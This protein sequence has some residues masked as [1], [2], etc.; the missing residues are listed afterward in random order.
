MVR[1]KI[2]ESIGT[3]IT[4]FFLC[5]WINPIEIN[6]INLIFNKFKDYDT[7]SLSLVLISDSDIEN[8]EEL[9]ISRQTLSR[10][11]NN[12]DA[13]YFIF[14]VLFSGEKKD[15][16]LDLFSI[17]NQSGI[18]MS[19]VLGSNGYVIYPDPS[20]PYSAVGFSNIS[21][22]NPLYRRVFSTI[23][24]GGALLTLESISSNNI[25]EEASPY[26]G[27]FTDERYKKIILL[28][29]ESPSNIN[30]YDLD[31]LLSGNKIER[32]TNNKVVIIGYDATGLAT[33]IKNP[34]ILNDSIYPATIL[35]A[36]EIL[37][38]RNN[39]YLLVGNT[40]TIVL[41]SLGTLLIKNIFKYSFL[42][43]L[44]SISITVI[45]SF[46]FN[47]LLSSTGLILFYIIKRLSDFSFK[48]I[49]IKKLYMSDPLTGI[50]NKRGLELYIKK[51]SYFSKDIIYY[52]ML[53]IDW[54]KAINDTYGHPR[55]DE[56]IIEVAKTL[57]NTIKKK[58]AA[59]RVGGEEFCIVINIDPKVKEKDHIKIL[60]SIY[61]RISSKIA[62]KKIVHPTSTISNFITL[63]AGC[64]KTIENADKALYIS[65][66][67]SRNT[68]TYQD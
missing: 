37:S 11:I 68:F 9:P 61:E 17:E 32:D 62:D 39:Y 56:I 28:W 44:L 36:I 67:R 49:K 3:F 14:D 48:Y 22:E 57:K 40:S 27:A 33:H 1:S 53:D 58:D 18:I 63:S 8:L 38:R 64:S 23:S 19:M 20:I 7:Y 30:T 42:V 52:M 2:L 15:D 34:M 59:A 16:P 66:K 29:P 65:K 35:H 24:L 13:K 12:I 43:I 51:L 41:F 50:M 21:T 4:V 46:Y 6:I 54:F 25:L 26:L 31:Y 60:N 5:F 10:A 45:I 47:I 55:G